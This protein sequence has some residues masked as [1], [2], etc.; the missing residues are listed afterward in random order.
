MCW[1]LYFAV[2]VI[3]PDRQHSNTFFLLYCWLTR[4]SHR[5]ISRTVWLK[6][7][8]CKSKSKGRAK[9]VCHHFA[10]S[11]CGE[12][13]SKNCT[14]LAEHLRSYMQQL[15]ALAKTQRGCADPR[16]LLK[17]C[18]S[19]WVQWQVPLGLL[20][21]RDVHC[22]SVCSWGANVSLS[23][24]RPYF[25]SFPTNKTWEQSPRFLL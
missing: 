12:E 16:W 25:L 10:M 15:A 17:K 22:N 23:P 18:G 24:P 13:I 6:V 5:P 4:T 1:V 8:P 7:F 14:G 3:W 2:T 21:F 9:Q 20:G 19:T 11:L